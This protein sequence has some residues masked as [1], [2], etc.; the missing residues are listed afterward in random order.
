MNILIENLIEKNK[1]QDKIID[2][3]NKQIKNLIKINNTNEKQLF[4][5]DEIT[6]LNENLK[7]NILNLENQINVLKKTNEN[8][9]NMI[10]NLKEEI[11]K[12]NQ[13]IKTIEDEMLE[14]M[15]YSSKKIFENEK[16]IKNYKAIKEEL[17]AKVDDFQLNLLNY[18]KQEIELQKLHEKLFEFEFSLKNKKEEIERVIVFFRDTL[19]KY[20]ES[21]IARKEHS[22]QMLEILDTLN[23]K[24]KCN[25]VPFDQLICNI[26]KRYLFKIL[27]ENYYCIFLVLLIIIL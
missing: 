17:E 11:E 18:K 3:A 4:N 23:E 6:K 7:V 24:Y 1:Q 19:L 26:F 25:D 22:K 10:K 27:Y 16:E 9:S 2:D 14:K 20:L 8:N 21:G 15:N 5:M 12:K 13:Q